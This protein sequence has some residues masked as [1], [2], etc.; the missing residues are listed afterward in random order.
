MFVCPA[1]IKILI[2]SQPSAGSLA[3]L[4]WSFLGGAHLLNFKFFAFNPG[5]MQ[6]C[7]VRIANIMCLIQFM[8][9]RAPEPGVRVKCQS[10]RGPKK[11]P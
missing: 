2:R 8:K 6:S 11:A 5:K 7:E 1:R 4:L 3:G 9:I 10:V